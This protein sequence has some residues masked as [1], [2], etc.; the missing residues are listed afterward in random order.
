MK[1]KPYFQNFPL[2]EDSN[3]IEIYVLDVGGITYENWLVFW[4]SSKSISNCINIYMGSIL[5]MWSSW[6]FVDFTQTLPKLR[7]DGPEIIKVSY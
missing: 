5:T 2:V 1:N 6:V 7:T 3:T 4:S